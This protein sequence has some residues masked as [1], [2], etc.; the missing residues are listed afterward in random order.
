MF[1]TSSLTLSGTPMIQSDLKWNTHVTHMIKQGSKRLFLLRRLKQFSLPIDDMV[2]VYTTYIRPVLE[3]AAPVWSPGLTE[4][5]SSQLE[6]VQKRALRII[7]GNMYSDYAEVSAQLGLQS[8]ATRREHL[9]I[10]F[11]R[12]LLTN[13]QFRSLLPPSRGQISNRHVH[14]RHGNQLNTVRAR[15]ERFKNS[16]IPHIVRLLNKDL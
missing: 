10:Q 9:C 16:T 6:S 3:Y 15:T 11:G 4:R 8:R 1:S 5:Q 7:L 14:T 12:K 2:V 13:N